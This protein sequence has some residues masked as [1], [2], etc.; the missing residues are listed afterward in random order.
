V[1]TAPREGKALPRAPAERGTVR[2]RGPSSF[3]GAGVTS[4]PPALTLR[5][6]WLIPVAGRALDGGWVRIERRRIVA[7]GAGRPSG[8][9]TDLGDVV[10]LPGLVNAHTHLEFSRLERPIAADGGLPGWIARLVAVR[11]QAAGAGDHRSAVADGL[12]ES[13]AA[14]VTALGEIATAPMPTVPRPAP[15]LRV[16]RECLGLGPAAIDR[17]K[18]AL[19]TARAV[20]PPGVFPG[21]SPH[22]PYSVAAPLARW[23]VAAAR[24]QRLPLALH[25]AESADEA[26]LIEDGTGPFRELLEGL[27]AWPT[28]PPSL[29]TA[30]QWLALSARAPRALVVH[31]THLAGA[32]PGSL[33]CLARHRRRLAVAVCPRTA[34]L[35]A[36]RLPPIDRLRATGV[37]LALGT[38]GRGSAPDLDLRAECRTLVEAGLVSPAEALAMATVDAAW[39]IGL[40]HLCGRLAV[41]RPG[42]LT[43]I[44]TGPT[45]DPHAALLDPAARVV[46]TL[47]GGRVAHG[48][49]PDRGT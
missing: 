14:G 22:A 41:G 31:A 25:L 20:A 19:A 6:R 43:A 4:P 38:D 36:G 49:V 42:D 15:R 44:A 23:L 3:P 39:G 13:L 33:E 1:T 21:V 40:E 34:L 18:A 28:P 27:G 29:L 47:V 30:P 45:G 5:A 24:R 35:L 17:A 48:S 9:T 10:L 8:P 16:Y 26:G 12:A 46:L 32:A 11:R 37:R 2:S 7:I